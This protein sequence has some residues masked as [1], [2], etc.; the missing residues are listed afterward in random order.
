[1]PLGMLTVG[2]MVRAFRAMPDGSPLGMLTVDEM[3]EA[4]RPV[5]HHG[6]SRIITRD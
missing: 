4:I 5:S 6:L 1:M 3:V 2:K